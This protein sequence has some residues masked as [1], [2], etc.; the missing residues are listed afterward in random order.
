V[1]K[2]VFISHS[3]A[4]KRVADRLCNL[5]EAAGLECW[6]APRDIRPSELWASEIVRGIGTVE[7][8]MLIASQRSLASLQ[9]E[10]EVEKAA[11]LEKRLLTIRL[12]DSP[13]PDSFKYFLESRHWIDWRDGDWDVPIRAVFDALGRPPPDA[14]QRPALWELMNREPL[15]IV[16]SR[17]KEQFQRWER[18]G[19]VGYGDTRALIDLRSKLESLGFSNVALRFHDNMSQDDREANLVLV[20]GPDANWLSQRFLEANPSVTFRWASPTTH[21]VSLV[22]ERRAARYDPALG[23]DGMH[24]TDF[25]VIIRGH[26][27]SRPERQALLLA[28]SFGFGTWACASMAFSPELNSHAVVTAERPFEA[29][30]KVD[31]DQEILAD[32]HLLE[33][34]ELENS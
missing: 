24:G 29:L 34:R 6:I 14:V 12:D 21:V 8:F 4:D 28:G 27:P 30:V 9:V 20:G 19:L 7:L 26:N 3:S 10:R 16:G 1:G 15:V 13:M 25:G 31:V 17:W 5:L 23:G 2:A 11:D 32:V 22:D 18:S 33:V